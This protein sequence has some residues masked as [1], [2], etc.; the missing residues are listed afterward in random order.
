MPLTFSHPPR[1][2][3]G[4][5]TLDVG[6]EHFHQF[7]LGLVKHETRTGFR[8]YFL[9]CGC[10][11]KYHG[12]KQYVQSTECTE[13]KRQ[14]TVRES[15]WNHRL[16]TVNQHDY[17]PVEPVQFSWAPLADDWLDWQSTRF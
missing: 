7:A 4:L 5:P 15:C 17:I 9:N 3:N 6:F 12:P 1:L 2:S 11:Q 13:R 8:K 10:Q 16:S 14:L